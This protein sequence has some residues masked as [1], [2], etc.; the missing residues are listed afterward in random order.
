[1]KPSVNSSK[2]LEQLEGKIER[3]IVEATGGYESRLVSRLYDARMPVA[4]VNPAG[5]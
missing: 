4:R 2:K 5:A 1:M 3:I